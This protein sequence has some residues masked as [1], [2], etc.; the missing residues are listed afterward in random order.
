MEPIIRFNNKILK[1]LDDL[2]KVDP[3]MFYVPR[4]INNGGRMD[5]GYWFLGN[6]HYLMVSFWDGSDWKEKVHNIGFVVLKDGTSYA[7]LSAQDDPTG[8]G[9][10]LAKIAA[11]I[12]GFNK[13]K[14]KCKWFYHFSGQDYIQNLDLF[15]ENVK[16]VIDELVAM[17]RP[18]GISNMTQPLFE[19]YTRRLRNIVRKQQQCG[20]TNKIARICWNSNDWKFPSGP[21]GKSKDMGSFEAENGFGHEEWLFD[22]SRIIDGYHYAFLQ[23]LVLKSDRHV[24]KAYNIHLYTVNPKGERLYVGQLKGAECI[25]AQESLRVYGIY[26]NNGWLQEMAKEVSNTGGNDTVFSNTSAEVFFN[27]R[28]RI[29][30]LFRPAESMLISS[31]DNNITKD[32]YDLLPMKSSFVFRFEPDSDDF[33]GNLKN[34]KTRKRS[35]HSECT[36]NPLHDRMQNAIFTL[37]KTDSGYKKIY[38]QV[39]IEKDRVD[40]KAK[41]HTGDWHYFEVKTDCAK[42][43]IRKALGQILEYAHYPDRKRATKLIIVSDDTPGEDVKKYL[44]FIR[45]EYGIMVWYRTFIDGVL[46]DDY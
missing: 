44:D 1:H 4:K 16:P 38:R 33:D 25:D 15:L 13:S 7:E 17:H 6:N 36:Y 10:F 30:D 11:Q 40:V 21:T 3:G 14:K 45:N 35:C 23:P 26:R 39:Q 20:L 41:T 46:S 22:R 19:R 18:P 2:R 29:G 43:S 32:R 37:L 27:V 8:K 28:F 24:G 42:M 34:T 9:A 5:N 12:P 31:G